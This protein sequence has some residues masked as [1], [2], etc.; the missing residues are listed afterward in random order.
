MIMAAYSTHTACSGPF[1]VALIR[2]DAAGE[3]TTSCAVVV[4]VALE[5]PLPLL[6]RACCT[7]SKAFANAAR[8]SMRRLTAA[9]PVAAATSF[10]PFAGAP[11]RIAEPLDDAAA[12]F[13]A[14]P[15]RMVL[16]SSFCCYLLLPPFRSPPSRCLD[17]FFLLAPLPQA[18]PLRQ[19]VGHGRCHRGHHRHRSRGC[20]PT[21]SCCPKWST[22]T[23][24][25]LHHRQRCYCCLPPP[26]RPR[27]LLL[28][29]RGLIPDPVHDPLLHRAAASRD[30]AT[31]RTPAR[32]CETQRRD[33]S[34]SGR[35]SQCSL[36][37]PC[38]NATGLET[39]T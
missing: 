25:S 37:R 38:R 26:S 1:G 5:A 27:S 23:R 2:N 13:T 8:S 11:P 10:S 30:P 17:G 33:P 32:G 36:H 19:L 22:T 34:L 18:A 28:V 39:S 12:A 31:A 15:S 3:G 29:L 6:L 14:D 21:T 7:S 35:S 9:A 20:S 16:F 4:I 24:W